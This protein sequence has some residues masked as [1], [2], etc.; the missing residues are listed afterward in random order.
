MTASSIPTGSNS[1]GP[2]ARR[3][4]A[5]L[6]R[7]EDVFES[8]SACGV[9]P[10]VRRFVYLAAV[11]GLEVEKVDLSESLAVR[12]TAKDQELLHMWW[13]KRSRCGFLV[14]PGLSELY[15]AEAV[16]ALPRTKALRKMDVAETDQYLD[17]LEAVFG[18]QHLEDKPGPVEHQATTDPSPSFGDTAGRSMPRP[19]REEFAVPASGFRDAAPSVPILT[20]EELAAA[21][22]TL[23]PAFE[24]ATSCG[25]EP[26]AR[27]FA[28]LTVAENLDVK[29]VE[30]FRML[31]ANWRR[32][33]QALFLLRWNLDGQVTGHLGIEEKQTRHGDIRV[34]P[35][36]KAFGLRYTK[37]AGTLPEMDYPPTMST[38]EINRYTDSFLDWLD[39]F[40]GTHAVP[41]R[42]AE[43]V[44]E[45]EE[46][47]STDATMAVLYSVMSLLWIGLIWYSVVWAPGGLGSTLGDVQAEVALLGVF[48]L[49]V[50][51]W[52]LIYGL[53]VRRAF[54]KSGSDQGAEAARW[55]V[56]LAVLAIALALVLTVAELIRNS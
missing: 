7:F 49:V 18:V 39:T 41:S 51:V 29:W 52:V 38:D 44:A 19:D 11:A 46:D 5:T 50:P 10:Q 1:M 4:A 24:D 36:E 48:Y 21:L 22:G 23:A 3:V 53:K 12:D 37:E 40:L 34:D 25:V 26:Q 54:R 15:G 45:S 8:A 33:G 2:D 30:E 6:V 42:Q 55:A 56:I 28:E 35:V 13:Y 32:T 16:H 20:V 27:R 14:S 47:N 43:A 9:G 17:G 31:T